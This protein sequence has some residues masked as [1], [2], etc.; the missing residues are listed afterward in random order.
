MAYKQTTLPLTWKQLHVRKKNI[1]HKNISSARVFCDLSL[2]EDRKRTRSVEVL[3]S[4]IKKTVTDV[5]YRMVCSLTTRKLHSYKTQSCI[6]TKQCKQF[7]SKQAYNAAKYL[8]P[9]FVFGKS[10]HSLVRK[11]AN[12]AEILRGPSREMPE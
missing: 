12:V 3:S 6:K 7:T 2:K 4:F 8:T 11:L 9:H 10:S 5:Q 1:S